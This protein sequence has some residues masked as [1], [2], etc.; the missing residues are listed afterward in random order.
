MKRANWRVACL[1]KNN[2]Q[3]VVVAVFDNEE[4]LLKWFKDVGFWP[5]LRK[6]N[7]EEEGESPTEAYLYSTSENDAHEKGFFKK[8]P[9]KGD[10]KA[11]YDRSEDS[12]LVIGER[13]TLD[14]IYLYRYK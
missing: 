4:D 14:T 5:A 2:E 11:A 9:E 3:T 7:D 6:I 1:T 10:D 13:T 12:F 8:N